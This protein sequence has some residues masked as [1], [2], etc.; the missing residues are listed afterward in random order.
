MTVTITRAENLLAL[1]VSIEQAV[2]GDRHLDAH[3]Y[4]ALGYQTIRERSH[5]AGIAWRWRGRG[6]LD[7]YQHTHWSSMSRLTFDASD[8]YDHLLRPLAPSS[9]ISLEMNASRA[10]ASMILPLGPG[11]IQ[12]RCK[13]PALALC[14]LAMRL[15]HWRAENPIPTAFGYDN[16]R[17][18]LGFDNE[19]V[20][21]SYRNRYTASPGSPPAIHFEDMV[22]KGFARRDIVQPGSNTIYAMTFEGAIRAL[23]PGE[24][25]CGE[26]FPR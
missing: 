12:S 10:M 3:I 24:A 26:D 9:N 4:D 8:A 2:T 15:M 17:H 19:G 13:T 6:P 16:A 23:Q 1:A 25:L 18:A 14:G 21:R 20:K 22:V 5:A 7:E 11:I